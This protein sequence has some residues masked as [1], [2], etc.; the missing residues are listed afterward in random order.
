MNLYGPADNFGLET[1]HVILALI[2]KCVEATEGRDDVIGV[3]GSGTPTREFLY[4]DDAA[5]A[6]VAGAERYE[7]AEPV[8]LGTGE[9]ISIRDFAELIAK[10]T[11]ARAAFPWNGSKP[12]GQPRRLSKCRGAPEELDGRP[13]QRWKRGYGR[14]SSGSSSD[15]RPGSAFVLHARSG[16]GRRTLVVVEGAAPASGALGRQRTPTTTAGSNRNASKSSRMRS[17]G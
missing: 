1:S 15:G 9:E 10:L 3:W 17:F 11:G 6:I 16:S 5:E 8:K 7:G 13:R 4:V 12:D 14:P 2:R